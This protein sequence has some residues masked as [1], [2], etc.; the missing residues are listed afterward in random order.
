M[1][2]CLL[3]I[4]FPSDREDLD[5]RVSAALYL[6]GCGGSHS[7]DDV[8][9]L[10]VVTAYFESV[11]QRGAVEKLL[12]SDLDSDKEITWRSVDRPRQDWLDLYQ[13]SLVAIPVGR[14]FIVAPD[15]ALIRDQT[16]IPLVIPQEQAFG[17][18]S[19]ETTALCLEMLEGIDHDGKA[20]LDV[21]TGSAILALAMSR[22]GA[23]LVIAFDND[24]EAIPPAAAN[25]VRNRIDPRSVLLFCG[26]LL[27]VRGTFEVVTM[28]ILPDVIIPLLPDIGGVVAS[29]GSLILSGILISRSDEVVRAAEKIGLRC[30]AISSRGEWWCGRF[31]QSS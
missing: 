30:T 6:A 25:L 16:R 8:A 9:G 21:G 2:D 13:Q 11:E 5:D 29:D 15:R 17:T 24:L 27:A 18:G 22:L 20:G 28:N 23:R 26:T 14:R 4:S 7:Q 1:I 10:R 19:H 31:Q 12:D 3:E